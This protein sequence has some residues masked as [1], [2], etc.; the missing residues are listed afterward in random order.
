M[1]RAHRAAR[2]RS[3]VWFSLSPLVG[4]IVRGK[5]CIAELHLVR[6]APLLA[7]A[8]IDGWRF[9]NGS[10]GSPSEQELADEFGEP[11][12]K[13][14]DAVCPRGDAQQ[15]IGDHRG[16]DLQTD[17][18]LVGAEELADIE[19]LFDP[20]EQQLDLPAA[21]VEGGDLDCGASKIVGEECHH[22]AV[23]APDLDAPERDRKPGVAL[24]GENDLV[25]GDDL[26]AVALALTVGAMLDRAKTYAG[27]PRGDEESRSIID[28]LPPVEAAIS[29]VEHI[30]CA[31]FDWNL[32]ADLD[33]VHGVTSMAVGISARG[34]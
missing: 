1:A 12:W 18:I 23:L 19:M 20:P 34:S 25:I 32:T 24:A 16:E 14:G 21:L 13:H 29:L 10:D 33:V 5:L 15:Q 9:G 2:S 4:R 22:S 7:P 8:G 28:L 6:G 17:G 27:F 3:R 26:E 30:G 11:E 31:G